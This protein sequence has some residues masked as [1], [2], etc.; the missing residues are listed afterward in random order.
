M[1]TLRAAGEERAVSGAVVVRAP[2]R[3]VLPHLSPTSQEQQQY[4]GT[5]TKRETSSTLRVVQKLNL[6]QVHPRVARP[7]AGPVWVGRGLPAPAVTGDRIAPV[8]PTR[9]ARGRPNCR[10]PSQGDDARF[11]RQT[12]PKSECVRCRVDRT[13]MPGI[14][15][16]LPRI[17]PALSPIRPHSPRREAPRAEMSDPVGPTGQEHPEAHGIPVTTGED[18]PATS[19]PPGPVPRGRGTAPRHG[20]PPRTGRA[21][22]RGT[23]CSGV[24]G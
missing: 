17:P 23:Y 7:R 13:D 19:S 6:S 20:R 10:R 5:Y 15:P 8:T 3:Q 14:R 16:S 21:G 12:G 4:L 18:L 22:V 24:L 9:R 11:R 2:R 1:W